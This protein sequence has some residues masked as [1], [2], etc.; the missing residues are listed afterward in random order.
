MK[1]IRKPLNSL[2]FSMLL[3]TATF[4][5]LVGISAYNTP[6]QA[7]GNHNNSNCGIKEYTKNED[8]DDSRVIIDF[9]SDKSYKY[10]YHRTITITGKNGWEVTEVSLDVED[11]GHADYYVYSNGPLNNY[12]PSGKEIRSAK[13]TVEKPCATPTPEQVKICHSFGWDGAYVEMFVDPSDIDG[14]GR[15]DH[16]KNSHEDGYD[17]IPGGSWD[18]NGRNWDEEGKAIWEN[19]CEVPENK[20][21]EPTATP[22]PTIEPTATPT[23]TAEPTATP[24]PTAEPTATPTPTTEPSVTPTVEPTATPTVEPTTTPEVTVT[25]EPTEAG[26]V[27]G[28][29]TVASTDDE[30]QVLADTGRSLNMAMLAGAMIMGALIFVNKENIEKKIKDLR[31][32]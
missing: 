16:N 15:F 25:V 21:E 30:G 9:E 23:P 13:V 24:T 5:Y 11:D 2:L 26:S 7:T 31:K 22:T 32:N 19:D 8:F 12:N 28:I 14:N 18:W 1:N 10:D 4:T 3:I 20:C 29:D 27:Q 17:I 6:V